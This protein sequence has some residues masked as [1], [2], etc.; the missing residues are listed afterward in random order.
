MAID[1]DDMI[2]YISDMS[3]DLYGFRMRHKFS[4]MTDQELVEMADSYSRDLQAEFDREEA[5]IQ[6]L[7][8]SVGVDAA[9]I[10]RWQSEEQEREYREWDESYAAR[11][12]PQEIREYDEVFN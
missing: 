5:E 6:R 11:F 8:N 10:R 1:R 7:A 3:K 12:A 2:S 4:A 9:T